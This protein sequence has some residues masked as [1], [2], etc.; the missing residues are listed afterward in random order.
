MKKLITAYLPGKKIVDVYPKNTKNLISQMVHLT[1]S[2]KLNDIAL[3]YT[4][5]N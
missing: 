1:N 5:L 3:H 4:V 2:F